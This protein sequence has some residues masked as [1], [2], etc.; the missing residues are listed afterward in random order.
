MP[1][2]NISYTRA[3]TDNELH[4]ILAIQK[5]NIA[6]RITTIEKE[7]EGFITIGHDFDMLKRMNDSCPHIIAKNGDQVAGYALVMLKYFRNEIHELTPMFDTADKILNNKNYIVMGQICIAKEYR[8]MGIFKGLYNYYQQ[9]L[10][11]DYE[12]L[13]TEVASNNLRSLGAHKSVGF[14]I[15]KTQITDSVSWELMVWNWK[16]PIF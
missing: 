3:T 6:S 4:Q 12:C 10:K 15:V 13:F 2:K 5:E 7:K 14:K 9:E 11:N 16:Q 8:K 1:A